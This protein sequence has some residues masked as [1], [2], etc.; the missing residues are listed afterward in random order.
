MSFAF[1]CVFVV[2]ICSITRAQ[3]CSH[4]NKRLAVA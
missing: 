4:A 2:N 3:G 1:L